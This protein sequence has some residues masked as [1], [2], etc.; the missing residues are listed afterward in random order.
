MLRVQG[1][2]VVR[3]SWNER[4][5]RSLRAWT[6]GVAGSGSNPHEQWRIKRV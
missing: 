3:S 1:W 6:L 4:E 5:V 2:R